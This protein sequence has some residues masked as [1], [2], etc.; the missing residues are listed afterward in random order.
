MCPSDSMFEG[1]PA[2]PGE[3]TAVRAHDPKDNNPP[4]EEQIL[5]GFT[6][7]VT[8]LGYH[9]RISELLASTARVPTELNDELAGKVGD[10]CKQVR[11]IEQAVDGVRMKHNRQLLDAQ[12]SLK[13][14][15]DGMLAPLLQ[16]LA[17][18][19]QRL[20]RFVADQARKAEEARRAA[21]E[22]ARKAQEEEQRRRDEAAAAGR[23]EEAHAPMP[24]IEPAPAPPAPIMRGD[25]GSTVSARSVWHHEIESVRQLPDRLLKHPRVLEALD[26]VVAA[27]IRS[28]ARDIKGVRIWEEKAAAV[29]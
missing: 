16:A 2:W 11:A 7:E 29:R 24:V 8:R 20:D 4:L 26:K 9:A 3:E 12:R 17:P 21:A 18:I 28:G 10:L 27:E 6:D 23:T 5:M 13:G 22:A 15:S 19:R 14:K 25:L 1:A